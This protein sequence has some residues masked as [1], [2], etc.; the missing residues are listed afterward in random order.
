MIVK[1]TYKD[2]KTSVLYAESVSFDNV[3]F[4]CATK[5]RAESYRYSRDNVESVNVMQ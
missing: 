3:A 5:D 1:I 2:G 4:A